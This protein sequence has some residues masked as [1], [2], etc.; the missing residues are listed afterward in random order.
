M[1]RIGMADGVSPGSPFLISVRFHWPMQGP[2]AFAST[3]PPT[4]S[5]DLNQA[6]TLDGGPDLLA[7]RGD[8]EGHLHI[9]QL[10]IAAAPLMSNFT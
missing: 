3:V 7:A 1:P 8:G 2:Q 4:L 6:V 9:N 10:C 5:E